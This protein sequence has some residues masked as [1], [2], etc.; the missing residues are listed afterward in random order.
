MLRARWLLK[1]PKWWPVSTGTL[2]N[3]GLEHAPKALAVGCGGDLTG[4]YGEKTKRTKLRFSG[5][6][7]RPYILLHMFVHICTGSTDDGSRVFQY[8]VPW[9]GSVHQARPWNGREVKHDAT[10]RQWQNGNK[11][12][13]GIAMCCTEMNEVRNT[14]G[15][16]WKEEGS[17][18]A[19][20]LS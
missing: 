7:L 6:D 17:I 14:W 12:K 13:K 11:E 8:L 10:T 20:W 18:G 2:G 1:Q 3:R 19:A 16:M 4:W 15:M 5:W 9:G